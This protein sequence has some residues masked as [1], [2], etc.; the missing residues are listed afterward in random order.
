MTNKSITAAVLLVYSIILPV[1]AGETGLEKPESIC[2][3]PVTG[4]LY[5]SNVNGDATDRDGNGFISLIDRDGTVKERL[6]LPVEGDPPL[7]APKGMCIVGVRKDDPKTD[8]AAD[9]PSR[10]SSPGKS[11]TEAAGGSG[12]PLMGVGQ[13]P[14]AYHL[15]VADIDRVVI[16]NLA[17]R[18]QHAVIDLAD[19]KVAFANDLC[20]QPGAPVYLSDSVTDRLFADL[21]LA[22]YGRALQPMTHKDG[23]PVPAAL[24]KPNGLALEWAETPPPDDGLDKLRIG[25]GIKGDFLLV[26]HN[27]IVG[28]YGAEGYVWRYDMLTGN[29]EKLPFPKGRW[30][31]VAVWGMRKKGQPTPAVFATDWETGSLW[32]STDGKSATPIAEGMKG[33]ADFCLLK[34]GSAILIP[35]MLENRVRVVPVKKYLAP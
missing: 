31:G 29:V 11:Q 3:H 19:E 2:E 24:V 9:E 8:G 12:A 30:D 4:A 28:T 5:C 10:Q 26:T 22:P 6:F 16:Y 13:K 33:P 27:L 1:A 17:K 32:L 7:D 25:A 35:L 15:W 23:S 20:H 14:N 18:K 21:G 34:D